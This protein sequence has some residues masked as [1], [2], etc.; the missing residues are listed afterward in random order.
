MESEDIYGTH[1]MNTDTRLNVIKRTGE[2]VRAKG[3]SRRL[4]KRPTMANLGSWFRN[5]THDDVPVSGCHEACS[6]E[7]SGGRFTITALGGVGGVYSICI[8]KN[9]MA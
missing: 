9:K 3:F 4:A 8:F 2:K 7:A 6:P 1:R 5:Y